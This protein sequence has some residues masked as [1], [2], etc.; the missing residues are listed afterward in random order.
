MTAPPSFASLEAA[1][2][3]QEDSKVHPDEDEETEEDHHQHFYAEECDVDDDEED[4]FGG[5]YSRG[6]QDTLSPLCGRYVLCIVCV[7]VRVCT[8]ESEEEKQRKDR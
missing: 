5:R 2:S 1:I 6:P 8:R 3:W 4:G 7:F